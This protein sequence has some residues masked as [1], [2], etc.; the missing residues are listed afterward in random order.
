MLRCWMRRFLLVWYVV[1][2]NSQ[3]AHNV[4]SFCN[5]WLNVLAVT[6]KTPLSIV[7]GRRGF[8]WNVAENSHFDPS[9]ARPQVHELI[10]CFIAGLVVKRR[11]RCQGNVARVGRKHSHWFRR[12]PRTNQSKN[13]CQ[14]KQTADG[15]RVVRCGNSTE[16]ICCCNW[17]E[18]NVSIPPSRLCRW[19]NGLFLS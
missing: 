2:L 10:Y 7:I 3:L 13:T 19:Q 6:L 14:L 12:V 17:C 15:F 16:H 1:E 11:E 8:P 9:P 4:H 18:R 5:C